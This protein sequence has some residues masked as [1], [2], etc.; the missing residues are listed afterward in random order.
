[1]SQ[2]KFHISQPK[3]P[4]R[5]PSV[6]LRNPSFAFRNPWF[7]FHTPSFPFRNPSFAFRNPWLA[8]RN[9]SF[10]FRNPSFAFRNPWF[11]FRNP[12]F[13]FRNPSFTFRNP[14]WVTF[15]RPD[16]SRYTTPSGGSKVAHATLRQAVLRSLTLHMSVTSRLN[17]SKRCPQCSV[18]RAIP[19]TG[20]QTCQQGESAWSLGTVARAMSK[21][22]GCRRIP[23]RGD[24]LRRHREDEGS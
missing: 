21:P 6:K 17:D 8:F 16:R 12:S 23:S 22:K 19:S 13:T 1:M 18:H 3:F 5:T 7:A 24:R 10:T 4:F 2:P 9:P 11:A 14:L 20:N 15:A